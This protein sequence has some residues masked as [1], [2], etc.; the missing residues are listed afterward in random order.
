[1]ENRDISKLK[2]YSFNENKEL[3]K[4]IFKLPIYNDIGYYNDQDLYNIKASFEYY[5]MLL[6]D[7]NLDSNARIFATAFCNKFDIIYRKIEKI[8]VK[9]SNKK[10]EE[11]NNPKISFNE[12]IKRLIM[13]FMFLIVSYNVSTLLMKHYTI[14]N[15]SFNFSSGLY[16]FFNFLNCLFHFSFGLPD[17]KSMLIF[18]LTTI[19]ILNIIKLLFNFFSLSIAP[20]SKKENVSYIYRKNL[21]CLF[22]IALP[23]FLEYIKF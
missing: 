2:E 1:M 8:N 17:I 21:K 16:E 5:Q 20:Y 10:T 22:W 12:K 19:M 9:N 14:K 15:I 11:E 18:L 4:N 3:L 7:G 13:S 23:Y 6:D